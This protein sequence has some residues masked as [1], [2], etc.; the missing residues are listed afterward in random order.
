MSAS[1]HWNR[2]QQTCGLSAFDQVDTFHLQRRLIEVE[3]EVSIVLLWLVLM[4]L[5]EVSQNTCQGHCWITYCFFGISGWSFKV[6][7]KR[8]RWM[9]LKLFILASHLPIGRCPDFP[10]QKQQSL[11]PSLRRKRCGS[12]SP[13]VQKLRSFRPFDKSCTNTKTGKNEREKNV[14]QL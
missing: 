1:N 12:F 5:V 7:M 3:G 6:A 9:I 2:V 4:Q 8:H 10:S 11:W 14:L 13:Y